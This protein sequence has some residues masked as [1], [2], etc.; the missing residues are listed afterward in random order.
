MADTQRTY[1]AL[2]DIFR[3]AQKAGS[4]TAQDARDLIVSIG[5]GNQ[6][7]HTEPETIFNE[8]LTAGVAIEEG[9]APNSPGLDTFVSTIQAHTYTGTGVNVKEGFFQIHIQH[10]YKKDTDVTMHVH[11]GHKI[12]VPSGDVKWQI[13][14]S[15]ARGY[16][17]GTFGVT[18]GSPA[19][20][21]GVLTTVQ[22]AGA[23][24]AHHITNDDD[25]TIPAD[26]EIEPDSLI[27]GRIFR[28]PAD[29]EDTFENDAFLLHID[30]HYQVGRLGGTSERNRPW[31]DEG[32]PT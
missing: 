7:I 13:E 1:A 19:G 31:T 17:A 24:F 22:T 4:I 14:Y 10:D 29:A 8:Y 12:A 2:L 11:W 21:S 27:I 9:A 16:E 18:T 23:Q 3:D 20:T 28:D 5:A 32:F 15:V 30:I 26:V 6:E 25:M